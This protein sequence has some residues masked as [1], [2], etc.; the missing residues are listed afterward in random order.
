M[1]IVTTAH[2]PWREAAAGALAMYFLSPATQALL[3]E[4][5]CNSNSN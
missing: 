3:I 2:D 1:T 4:Y 5:G